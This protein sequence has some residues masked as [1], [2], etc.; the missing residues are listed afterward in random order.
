[1]YFA[2]LQELPSMVQE[3]PRRYGFETSK[4]PQRTV[5]P[6]DPPANDR[7]LLEQTR[8]QVN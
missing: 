6:Q 2:V 7:D 8:L 1:M 4:A 3:E 5:K